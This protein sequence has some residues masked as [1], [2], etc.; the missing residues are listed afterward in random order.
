ML[1]I[2]N[3]SSLTTMK[4]L[5]FTDERLRIGNE[6]SVIQAVELANLQLVV[7]LLL[8][9]CF[10]PI[11]VNLNYWSTETDRLNTSFLLYFAIALTLVVCLCYRNKIDDDF[12]YLS[13]PIHSV[14]I[15]GIFFLII[16]TIA[17]PPQVACITFDKNKNLL[18]I[19][20]FKF[21]FWDR[22]IQY[23]LTDIL[24]ANL[25][26]ESV[27]TGTCYAEVDAVRIT[28]RRDGKICSFG[29]FSGSNAGSIV[30][31]INTFLLGLR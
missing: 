25:V 31:A 4:I 15:V 22:S 21:L 17:V 6:K 14:P 12:L 18:T 9:I 29:V 26:K 3:I 11:W 24:A 19:K 7:N 1:P 8:T 30:P 16:Y 28:R 5:E 27:C 20:K 2:Y 10:V 13:L 23:P